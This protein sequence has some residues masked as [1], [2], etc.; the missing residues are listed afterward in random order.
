MTAQG[1][2]CS[3]AGIAKAYEDFLDL[4]I[5]D[6]RDAPA[7]DALRRNGLKVECAQTIMRSS[8]D[9][10]GLARVALANSM[11]SI[12]SDQVS[13]ESSANSSSD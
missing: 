6:L 8:D 2:P 13:T 3:I 5:C 4:L 10:A 1:L 12:I 9:K 11:P 7:A